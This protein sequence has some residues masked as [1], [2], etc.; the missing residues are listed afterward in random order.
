MVS[1]KLCIWNCPPYCPNIVQTA[2]QSV[3]LLM[4]S[5]SIVIAKDGVKTNTLTTNSTWVFARCK[6]GPWFTYLIITSVSPK[7]TLSPLLSIQFF[8]A[9]YLAP[10]FSKLPVIIIKSLAYNISQDRLFLHFLE[11]LSSTIIN[12]RGLK[13]DP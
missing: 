3:P 8:Y 13:T 6:F 9:A 10:S 5:V 7:F 1:G 11:R 2:T 4:Y 12:N